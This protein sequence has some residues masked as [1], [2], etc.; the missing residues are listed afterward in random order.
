ALQNLAQYGQAGGTRD[1]VALE[2]MAFDKTG[3]F[4]AR[5]PKRI[6]DGAAAAQ[7]GNGSVAAA[8]TLAHAEHVRDYSEGFGSDQSPGAADAGDDR[9]KD[10][11]HVVAATDFT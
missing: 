1:R 5:S 11:Q 3:I 10:Q 7:R 9:V 2:G 4:G 6:G 8:Q